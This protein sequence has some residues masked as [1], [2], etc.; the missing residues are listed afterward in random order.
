MADTTTPSTSS[1]AA[2]PPGAGNA[3]RPT[4]APGDDAPA[5][6][7]SQAG[8]MNRVARFLT[9]MDA[10]SVRAIWIAA[11]LFSIA[12]AILAAGVLFVDV[13]QG[14]LAAYFEPVRDA[15]WAPLAVAAAFTVLAFIGAPQFVL[16]AA[17]VAVFT[18][19]Q[20]II[21]S[22][23]ATMA[24]AL[25]GFALGRAAGADAVSRFGGRAVRRI[26][27]FVGQNGFLTSAVIRNVP[28]APFIIVNMA[29]GAARVRWSHFIGGTGLGIVPKIVLVAFAGH[30]INELFRAENRAAILFLAAAAILWLLIVFVVRPWLGRR[31]GP[32]RD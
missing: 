1:P 8:P 24:S 5:E 10:K 14:P 6:A 27:G 4:D 11:V 23:C 32:A 7:G 15:W 25:V 2:T 22:W 9:E 3:S 13:Q 29:L 20:G 16:I 18:P 26:I 17:T 19:S 12:G 31:F 21:L 28:S 30:G